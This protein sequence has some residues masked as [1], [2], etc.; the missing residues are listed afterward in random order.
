MKRL[1][2]ASARREEESGAHM[3]ATGILRKI[4]D[5][6]QMITADDRLILVD[7]IMEID[8]SVIRRKKEEM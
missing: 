5:L 8:N 6:E 4:S 2:L 7:Q 3:T 1:T